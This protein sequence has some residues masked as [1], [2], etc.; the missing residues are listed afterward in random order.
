MDTVAIISEYNPFHKG[1]MYQISQVKKVLN[2]PTVVSLMSPNF[3]Q[4]GYP[5]LLDKFTRGECAIRGG[6]DLSLSIP[7]V[8]ALL[9]AEGFAE[10]GVRIAHKLGAN[11]LSFGVEDDNEELLNLIAELL[12]STRFEDRMKE[13]V[14]LH[15]ENSYPVIRAN[16]V[17]EFL[18]ANAY[19]FINKPNN[20]LAI[21]YLK[22]IKKYAPEMKIL[23]IK[24]IGNDYHDISSDG[25]YLSATALR[26]LINDGKDFLPFLPDSSVA[27]L[28]DADF[29]DFEEY[30]NFLYAVIYSKSEQA[31]LRCTNNKELTNIIKSAS[32]FYP[33]YDLFRSS[34]S[35]KKYTETKIDRVLLSIL[36]NISF[37][38]YYHKEPEYVTLLALNDRGK[39]LL[40][41][42]RKSDKIFVISKGADL[43]KYYNLSG[44]KTEI[45]ADRIYARCMATKKEGSY[46]F[47]KR[48]YKSEVQK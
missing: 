24:R 33:T 14:K 35:R 20:I 47:K 6:V 16:L 48:P 27:T 4:R 34:L 22:A 28:K 29:F 41:T 15:P 46:F 12:L 13:E 23:P 11:Y 1:H 18:G 10:S 43:K 3:V 19:K 2:H 36:L 7:L 8:F 9:S 39:K 32:E 21:E 45:F 25:E 42:L 17:K 37:E 31:I 5:A 40:S 38:E 30:K 26:T 44:M